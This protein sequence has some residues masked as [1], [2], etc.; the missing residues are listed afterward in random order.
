MGPLAILIVDFDFEMGHS[1]VNGG[2]CHAYNLWHDSF[3]DLQAVQTSHSTIN[4]GIGSGM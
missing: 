2:L 1:T 3:C 4:E